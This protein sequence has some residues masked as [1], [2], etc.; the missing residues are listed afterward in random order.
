VS[1]RLSSSVVGIYLV[2]IVAGRFLIPPVLKRIS[3]ETHLGVSLSVALAGILLF[4]LVP[5]VPVKAALCALYGLGVGP[6][7]PL[8]MARGSREFPDQ[9]GVVTGVLFGGMSLGGMVFPLLMG[10][11]AAGIGIART[12]WFCAV[13]AFG[14]LVA[15]LLAGK[16]PATEPPARRP[17]A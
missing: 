1:L 13:V 15:V 5:S 3:P 8:L 4:I 7:F 12:Y 14:L 10:S 16:P 2:G 17:P 11:I 9:S 6:V